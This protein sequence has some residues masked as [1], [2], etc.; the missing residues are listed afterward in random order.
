MLGDMLGVAMTSQRTV[1]QLWQVAQSLGQV[2]FP[3][4]TIS[5]AV[6]GG[7][8]VSRHFQPQFPFPLFVVVG[9]IAA[10]F[11]WDFAG[12][13]IAVVGPVP[14]GCPRSVSRA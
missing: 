8:L 6:V 12:R 14:G 7:I 10:S 3:T 11:A 5:A 2:H 9:A 1:D 4:L 13:G